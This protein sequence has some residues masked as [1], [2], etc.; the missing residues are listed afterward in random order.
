[1]LERLFHL[2]ANNTNVKTEV[3]AGITTFLTMAYITFVNPSI[4]ATTGM[5]A[6]AV[7]VATCLAA[8]FGSA[9]MGLLANYPIAIA[10][11]MGFN[12]YFTYSVVLNGGYSWS[13]ALGAVFMSSILFIA[14]SILPI[15]EYLINSVPKS[16]RLA[17]VAG[18]GLFLAIIGLKNAGL[19]VGSHATF[20]TLGNL[21]DPTVV[22]A[23]IGFFLMIAL[24]ALGFV[25]T[26]I[27]SSI[28]VVSV[29]SFVLG[30]HPFHGV[31]AMPPSL[32]PTFCKMDIKGA[33]NLGLGTIIF[34]FLFVNLLDTTGTLI[35]VAY[36]AGL[37]DKNG[38]LP[39]IRSAL[40]AD[41]TA[42]TVGAVLGTS[43]TTSFL[44]STTGIKVGGRTG[45]TAVVVA[46]L[47]VFATFLAPLAQ[48][49]PLYASAPAL[50][51]VAFLMLRSLTEL[52]W[53]DL[54]EY[55]PAL[56]TT[57]CIPLTFSISDGMAFGFIAYFIIKVC[58]GRY[59]DLNIPVSVMALAFLAK[60]TLLH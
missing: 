18:I 17:I 56:V 51:Y 40:L 28:L 46:I 55:A 35:G 8:A 47:F 37:L 38:K 57:I 3:I 39:R 41:S 10:P 34:T 50:I 53:Q 43:S 16:L 11:G 52:D 33:F 59:R 7:F 19:V 49:I 26:A 36:R 20:V 48:S 21:H 5:D 25:S 12:A 58:S 32:A 2:S 31:F 9:A 60:Y 4:L 44:E 6:G 29:A 24:E 1:M 14:I 23:I 15:R 30:Y 27:I 54:T 45:L 13:I 22:L 42:V